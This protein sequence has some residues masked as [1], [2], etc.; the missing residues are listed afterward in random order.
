MTGPL[1]M[2]LYDVDHP[3][4]VDEDI[5]KPGIYLVKVSEPSVKDGPR[6]WRIVLV[7]ADRWEHLDIRFVGTKAQARSVRSAIRRIAGTWEL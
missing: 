1:D 4:P 3:R 7:G 6:E 2:I 5:V